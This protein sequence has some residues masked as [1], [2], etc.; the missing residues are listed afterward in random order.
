MIQI[1]KLKDMNGKPVE[2]GHILAVRYSWNSYVG[3]ARFKGLC[4]EGAKRHA[5]FSPHSYLDTATYQILGHINTDHED[6]VPSV[7]DWYMSEQE[8]YSCP[9]KIRVYENF[10]SK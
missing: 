9:V 6:F 8:N 3:V 1:E 4:A 7:L 10:V 5:F 2:F